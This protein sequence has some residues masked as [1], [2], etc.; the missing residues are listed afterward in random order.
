MLSS[1]LNSTSAVK[2]IGTFLAIMFALAGSLTYIL[3]LFRG[4]SLGDIIYNPSVTLSVILAHLF[5]VSRFFNNKAVRIAHICSIVVA[6]LFTIAGTGLGNEIH[7]EFIIILS[8]MM[9]KIYGFL[10][11]ESR[12]YVTLSMILCFIVK[13][14]TN[15]NYIVSH[16]WDF[17]YY[18]ILV[19]F[20]AVFFLLILESEERKVSE[21]AAIICEQWTKE[22]VY[23][24]IGRTVFST[25]MHDYH[26]DHA[27]VHLDTLYEMI[28]DGDIEDAKIMVIE[29][30]KMLSNDNENILRVKDKIRLSVK[31]KPEVVD[32][33]KVLKDKV[34]YFKKAYKLSESN[35][36]F[37]YH[38]DSKFDLFIVPIDFSGI[39]ENLIKNAIEADTEEKKIKIL[40]YIDK[41]FCKISISNKGKMIPWRDK[42][43][44]VPISAFRV[45][46]TTKKKGSGWGVYSI[47]K[48]VSANNGLIKVTSKDYETE[49]CLKFPVKKVSRD[50]VKQ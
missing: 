32:S 23:N 13:F 9:A 21:E 38:V 42:D 43:G 50:M 12:V 24:D 17:I 5:Y 36:E 19:S 15:F 2:R 39:I 22:Q 6:G 31:D 26:T 11:K 4:E 41:E 35:I 1:R 3:S 20:F 10:G 46:R 16:P 25:F 28:D 34:E 48:R 49:F 8:I 14:V 45:G 33:I 47:I 18:V 30:K 44:N 40:M 7:G 29:L 37:F 27:I